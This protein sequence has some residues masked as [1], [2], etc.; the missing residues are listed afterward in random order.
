ML[1]IIF[2]C[3]DELLINAF[4]QPVAIKKNSYF[5][6]EDTSKMNILTLLYFPSQWQFRNKTYV[7]IFTAPHLILLTQQWSTFL[8]FL[9][10]G[11]GGG[12][13]VGKNVH[14]LPPIF[15]SESSF[16]RKKCSFMFLSS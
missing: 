2:F 9:G 6:M 3:P 13:Q 7:S 14:Q 15:F 4:T 1:L 11:V 10:G 12:C 8:F 16:R 5:L